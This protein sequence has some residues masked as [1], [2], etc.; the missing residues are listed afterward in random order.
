M[1]TKYPCYREQPDGRFLDNPRL[2]E[3]LPVILTTLAKR[4]GLPHLQKAFII[5]RNDSFSEA[6]RRRT[7]PAQHKSATPSRT[8]P[9][10]T[11][12]GEASSYTYR[13][14]TLKES[15]NESFW[16]DRSCEPRPAQPSPAQP[17]PAQPCSDRAVRVACLLHTR[18]RTARNKR[19]PEH[20]S[21]A[22][23]R[24]CPTRRNPSELNRNTAPTHTA[25]LRNPYTPKIKSQHVPP[26]RGAARR[27][28]E[29]HSFLCER[30][31]KVF[32]AL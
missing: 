24:T 6:P 32:D 8:A 26:V 31:V 7:S 18:G 21:T 28:E 22:S 2:Q 19:G 13:S 5:H 3:G 1:S 23:S 30:Y 17:S 15:L 11:T 29:R 4:A 25:A 9:G 10:H 12:L 27:T 14:H 16:R 20:P